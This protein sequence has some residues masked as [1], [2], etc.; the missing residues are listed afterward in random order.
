MVLLPRPPN[1]GEVKVVVVD[2]DAAPNGVALPAPKRPAPLLG[3]MVRLPKVPAGLPAG[4][5]P[6]VG[7]PAA[8]PAIL[9]IQS[10]IS[11]VRKIKFSKS[12]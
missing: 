11:P 1:G 9:V 10:I 6:N 5:R 7:G 12:I 8:C 2:P 3:L 4:L